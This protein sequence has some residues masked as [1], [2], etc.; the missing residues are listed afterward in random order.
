MS[1]TLQ[2]IMTCLKQLIA[3]G[4]RKQQAIM[5]GKHSRLPD[6][7]TEEMASFDELTRLIEALADEEPITTEA[8]ATIGEAVRRLQ[9]LNAANKE[10][11]QEQLSGV[12][13]CLELLSQAASPTYTPG[14]DKPKA[15]KVYRG[16]FDMR[17]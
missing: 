17:A 8:A 14:K 6:I 11:L 3:L 5:A 7:V 13:A 4:E 15:T 1:S 16:V 12:E 2:L 10:L 9:R